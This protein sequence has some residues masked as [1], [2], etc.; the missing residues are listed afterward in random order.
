MPSECKS[1]DL[2]KQGFLKTANLVLDL[3]GP[4]IAVES[5]NRGN[6]FAI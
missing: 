1:P 5:H 6:Q 2:G 4:R 3:N